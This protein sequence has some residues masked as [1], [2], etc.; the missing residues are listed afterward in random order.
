MSLLRGRME[1]TTCITANRDAAATLALN[2]TSYWRI[3]LRAKTIVEADVAASPFGY[4][5]IR[6]LADLLNGQ[7]A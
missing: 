3:L 1:S 5:N 2:A 4:R 7:V 6:K